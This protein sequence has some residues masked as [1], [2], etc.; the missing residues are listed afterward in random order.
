MGCHTLFQGVFPTQELNHGL[1]HRGWILL[2]AELP[3]NISDLKL[4]Y[5]NQLLAQFIQ[6]IHLMNA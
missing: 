4:G 2:P 1:L 5:E 3:R 6:Q